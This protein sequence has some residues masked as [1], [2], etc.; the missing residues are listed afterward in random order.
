MQDK[1]LY[2][3]VLGLASPWVV[4]RVELNVEEQRVD[5][6]VEHDSRVKWRCPQCDRELGCHDHTQ[7]RTWRHLDTCQF[8][9]LPVRDTVA[10]ASSA[11][12]LSGAW[13]GA[14]VGSVGRAAWTVHD[15]V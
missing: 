7:E 8:V 4:G 13:C 14:S 12:G 10:G 15:A 2:Q 3:Q 9:T 5:V 11:C 6:F 1:E